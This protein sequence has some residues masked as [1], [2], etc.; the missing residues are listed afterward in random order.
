[1]DNIKLMIRSYQK[2]LTDDFYWWPDIPKQK[3]A[4]V[5]SSYIALDEDEQLICLYG[6]TIFGSAKEGFA[7]STKGIY[8]KK[9]F[10]SNYL[11]YRDIEKI[12]RKEKELYISSTENYLLPTEDD[13]DD[14]YK[15]ILPD[16]LLAGKVRKLLAELFEYTKDNDIPGNTLEKWIK[17]VLLD[18]ERTE[19][20][21]QAALQAY[22]EAFE[23]EPDEFE[24][25]VNN[26]KSSLPSKVLD[27][28]LHKRI[29][30]CYNCGTQLNDNVKFCPNC[31]TN[32]ASLSSSVQKTEQ[33]VTQ[34]DDEKVYVKCKSCKESYYVENEDEWKETDIYYNC[35]CGKQIEVSF[36]G[37]C[38]KCNKYV[39]FR[40]PGLASVVFDIVGTVTGSLNPLKVVTGMIEGVKSD[41]VDKTPIAKEGYCPFCNKKH[42]K[43][44]KCGDS[45]ETNDTD[46]LDTKIYTCSNCKTRMR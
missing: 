27:A 43:C 28:G 6:S 22:Q 37:T 9:L 31:G 36:F 25:I 18:E 44:P 7:L 33:P 24:T 35:G 32:I 21:K 17:K 38:Y 16:S 8:W 12:K 1:M 3:L 23:I 41:F 39:G 2:K 45:I 15:L 5:L 34:E 13:E 19:K 29:M 4:N 30:Y 40:P 46:D 10:N 14:N 42:I 26:V 11:S 20:E